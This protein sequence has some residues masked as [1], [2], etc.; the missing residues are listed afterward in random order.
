MDPSYTFHLRDDA[1]WSDGVPVT[2]G[3]FEYAWKRVL[4]DPGSP[5]AGLLLYDIKGARAFHQGEMSDLDRV[6]IRA[7]DE[8]TLAV[9]L[10]ESSAYFLHLLAHPPPVPCPQHAVKIHGEAWMHLE[11]IV[12]NGPFRLEEWRSGELMR[13]SRNPRYQGR[14]AG[15]LQQVEL[16]LISDPAAKLALYE[17]DM[18][19]VFRVWFMSPQEMS[20][21]QQRH[22]GEYVSGPQLTTLYIGFDVTQSP[23]D[24][25]RVRQAFVQAI[26]REAHAE[27]VRSGQHS[28][29]TGGFVPTGMPGH[30]P[31][32]GLPYDPE[33]AHQLLVEAGYPKGRGFPA[34]KLLTSSFRAQE[35]EQL[36]GYWRGQSS[37]RG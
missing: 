8:T 14:F 11:N 35:S 6:G 1:R 19:D 29:A 12:T 9:E 36:A 27:V 33:R 20:R 18:L 16:V 26:D 17:A 28:L 15:N 37:G 30:S 2:A 3:D 5:L 7:L 10:E 22:A 21:A 31:G 23:F 4:S 13:F 34:V 32:I 24:D 25:H